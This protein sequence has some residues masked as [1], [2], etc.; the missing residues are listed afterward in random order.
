MNWG[1]ATT[2]YYGENHLHYLTANA[3]FRPGAAPVS[4]TPTASNS[5]C[6]ERSERIHPNAG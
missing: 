6:P 2:S 1:A 5:N 3:Q 4:W